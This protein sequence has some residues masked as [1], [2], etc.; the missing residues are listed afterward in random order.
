MTRAKNTNQTNALPTLVAILAVGIFATSTS[1]AEEHHDS[2]EESHEHTFHK[3]MIGAFIGFTGEDN[4]EG[5]GRERA[6]TLGLEYEHRFAESAAVLV[7]AERAFGDLDFTVI[8]GSLVYH[9][10]PWAF[11]AGTGIEI[12]DDDH[13][14]ELLFR[15]ASTY[16]FNLGDYEVAPKAG[17]DFI[18]NEVVFFGGLVVGFGF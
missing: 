18:N 16:A 13:D 14:N 1:L 9:H 8:T 10:G 5:S 6:F 3:N 15:I 2:H 11:S 17:L 12:P 4:R 7:A